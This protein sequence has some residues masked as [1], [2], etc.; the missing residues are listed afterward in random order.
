MDDIIFLQV[1]PTNF[2][3][4]KVHIFTTKMRHISTL[5]MVWMTML[6]VNDVLLTRTILLIVKLVYLE[7]MVRYLSFVIL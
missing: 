2:V 5:V 4:R 7:K 1:I 6:D 3:N